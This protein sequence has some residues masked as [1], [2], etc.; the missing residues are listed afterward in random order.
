MPVLY[1][2]NDSAKTIDA[3]PN[4]HQSVHL[5]PRWQVRFV[6]QSDELVER[7]LAHFTKYGIKAHAT[8]FPGF[9]VK[10]TVTVWRRA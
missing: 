6:Y 3:A 2:L 10:D 5:P 1:V 4:T 7:G 9:P 8:P